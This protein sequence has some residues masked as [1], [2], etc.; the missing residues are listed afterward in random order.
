MNEYYS[1]TIEP[2]SVILNVQKAIYGSVFES[3]FW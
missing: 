1:L 3:S 2:M